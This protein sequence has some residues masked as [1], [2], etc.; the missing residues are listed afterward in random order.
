M[1][2]RLL[3]ILS[4]STLGCAEDVAD[5][6]E[7]CVP[8]VPADL[9]HYVKPLDHVRGYERPATEKTDIDLHKRYLLAH[10]A[11]FRD[12]AQQWELDG[13]FD[14]RCACDIMGRDATWESLRGFWDGYQSF[15]TLACQRRLACGLTPFVLAMPAPIPAEPAVLDSNDV[16]LTLE[17]QGIDPRDQ[18]AAAYATAS[19]E[20]E[21][22]QWQ[23]QES[24]AAA[25]PVALITNREAEALW[26][27]L[28]CF[29]LLVRDGDPPCHI[30]GSGW[31][32]RIA[33]RD[34]RFYVDLGAS[35]EAASML[36]ELRS[37]LT[38]AN[39]GPVDT[40]IDYLRQ[41]MNS[42]T[43]RPPRIPYLRNRVE[44]GDGLGEASGSTGPGGSVHQEQGRSPTAK[45]P[46]PQRDGPRV[47]VFHD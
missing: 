12:A 31:V 37:E 19:R 11:G 36:E 15:K 32:V 21:L 17:W 33:S 3:V 22:K 29:D 41:R 10:K 26:G 18:H 24:T 8:E 35:D 42:P 4:M 34:K 20:E 30:R 23:K 38:D 39:R 45:L 14:Y 46:G 47:F 13:R 16:I 44:A 28:G 2:R 43:R 6:Y 7:Y 25:V 40:V 1:L 27:R 9:P 5:K